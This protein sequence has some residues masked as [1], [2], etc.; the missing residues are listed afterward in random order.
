MKEHFYICECECG[1]I[2]SINR[3]GLLGHTKS[4]GCLNHARKEKNKGWKGY[5]EITGFMWAQLKARAKNKE[6]DLNISIEE[7]WQQCEKQNKKCALTGLPLVFPKGSKK[8]ENRQHTA[9]LDRI[10]SKLGYIV[11]NIQ[12]VHKDVQFMKNCFSQD[13]F[14]EVCKLVVKYNS[15]QIDNLAYNEKGWSPGL[16]RTGSI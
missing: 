6:I 2:K 10:N 11:G 15:L 12:W 4:C 8:L 3:N 7:A 13:H 1:N 9:S 14:F 5:G 16:K